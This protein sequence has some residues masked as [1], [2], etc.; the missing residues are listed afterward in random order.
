MGQRF[1]LSKAIAAWRRPFELHRAISA[2]DLEELESGLRDRI[3]A[4]QAHGFAE[5][6]AFR[7]SMERMGSFGT[8]DTEYRKVYWGKLKREQRLTNEL[9]WRCSMLQNYVKIALR[10]LQKQIGYT[11]INVAGLA[12]G[13]T[14]FILIGLFVQHELSYDTFHDKADRIYRIVKEDPGSMYLGSNQYA[15]T[16]APMVDALME[17]FPEVEHAVNIEASSAY[18]NVDDV[19]VREDGLYA[20]KHFFDVFGFQLLKG[21]PQAALV[22]P[23]SILLTESLAQTLLGDRDPLGQFVTFNRRSEWYMRTNETLPMVVTGVVADP[24][25]NT[26]L[27]FG[28]LL[29]MASSEGYRRHMDEGHWDSNNYLTYATVRPDFSLPLFEEK[30][31]ALA[32][33]YLSQYTYYHNNPDRISI[34]FPQAITDI[35]LRSHLNFELQPNGDIRY[36]YLFG[37]IGLLIL[38]LA[39]INYVNLATARSVMRAKEVGVRKVMGAFRGQLVGQFMGEAFVMTGV[40]LCV[41]VVCA[42]LILPVFNALTARELMFTISE[43]GALLGG[44]LLVG[45]AVGLVAGMYPAFIMARFDAVGVMKGVLQQTTSKGRLRNGL[46]VFQFAV[47]IALIIG[48]VVIQQ[49]LQ[50][51][52][53][54]NTGVERDHVVSIR[55]Q[56]RALRDQYDALK[57]T[58]LRNPNVQAVT[59]STHNPTNIGSNQGTRR[60]EGAEDGQHIAPYNTRV[61]YGYVDLLGLELIEGRDFAEAFMSTGERHILI[62][63]T[64]MRQLGWET[65]VGKWFRADTIRVVGVVKDFNFQPFKQAIEPLEIRLDTEQFARVLV[66]IDPNDLPVTLAFL[67]ETMATFSPAFP[68]EYTFLNDAYNSM[69]ETEVRLGSLFS[70]FSGLALLIACLGL[71]GL[72]AFTASQRTKEIGVRKVLGASV[73]DI[74]LLL[75][76][77]FTRLVCIAFVVGTPVAHY[78]MHTW[79]QDFA[80]RITLGWGTFLLAGGAALVLAWLTVSYQ[81]FKAA[82]ANPV[83]TLRHE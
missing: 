50:Y 3:A 36:V 40:A 27:T 21:D 57:Q 37:M 78:A 51:I 70:Y 16:S 63:E 13:L 20:S 33:K 23:N 74:L 68:F 82:Y 12:V 67:E 11:A 69:Y 25:A 43:N 19:H 41:A 15:V 47:T 55:L 79:L 66:K 53:H 29:S 30:L 45:I 38:L 31:R 39:C 62:N 9:Y 22:E 64:M 49:Q 2:E 14:C 60:W 42:M 61:H 73:P 6:E 26:H 1:H 80:Y 65:S 58:L 32:Q 71:L 72:A 77:D 7:Q 46:V 75:S 59:A 44:L 24:P 35:H 4:L 56:D 83:D 8:A 52:Q 54:A 5:E 18:L 17:E 48:T 28:Y 34:Y 81:A 10:T 76:K